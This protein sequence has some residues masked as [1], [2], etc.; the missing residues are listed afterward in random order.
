MGLFYYEGKY[1]E[2]DDRLSYEY[3]QKGTSAPIS[4]RIEW[5]TYNLVKLFYLSGNGTLGIKKDIDKSI[6]LLSTIKDF[7][8]SNELLLYCYYEK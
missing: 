6:S 1:I 3:F 7:E 2:K 8:P 4:S 5:N